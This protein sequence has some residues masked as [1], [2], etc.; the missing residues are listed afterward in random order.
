MNSISI[1][2][3]DSFRGSKWKIA[4]AEVLSCHRGKTLHLTQLCSDMSRMPTVRARFHENRRTADAKVRQ[5]LQALR[6]MELIESLGKGYWR[7]PPGFLAP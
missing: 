4:L 7:V 5:Q 3:P 1:Q 2:V 6:D